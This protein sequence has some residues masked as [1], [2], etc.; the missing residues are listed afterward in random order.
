MPALHS[1][2][3]QSFYV[4]WALAFVIAALSNCGMVGAS[5]VCVVWLSWSAVRGELLLP[6]FH[7]GVELVSAHRGKMR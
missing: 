7:F 6:Y 5:V 4:S 2:G 1:I 3:L